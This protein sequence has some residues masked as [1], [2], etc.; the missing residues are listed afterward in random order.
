MFVF[1][2]KLEGERKAGTSYE[3]EVEA[4]Q[5]VPLARVLLEYVHCP[6]NTKTPHLNYKIIDYFVRFIIF[7]MLS[8]TGTPFARW[9]RVS[10]TRYRASCR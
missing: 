10:G 9:L 4:T 1:H 8:G 5:L 7:G 2:I 3:R 6:E